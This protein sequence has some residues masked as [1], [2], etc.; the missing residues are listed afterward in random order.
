[1]K[2]IGAIG[3]AWIVLSVPCFA[4]DFDAV[5]QGIESHYG[6]QRVNPHLIGFATFLA[7]PVLWGSGAGELKIAAF[8][9]DSRPL[10]PSVRELDKIMVSS[11]DPKWH[12]FVRVD[13]RKD[14][15]AVVIYSIVKDQHMTMMIGSVERDGISLV[16]IRISPKAFE[17]WRTSPGDKAKCASQTN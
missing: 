5:V 16:Q 17:D 3:L 12:P 1:M 4:D 6:I 13:S 11:L 9:N 15:E 14:G 7:K 2:R 10:K 8:E